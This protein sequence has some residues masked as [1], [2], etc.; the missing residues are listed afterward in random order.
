MKNTFAS[1]L[2]T[3]QTDAVAL[4]K[5]DLATQGFSICKA[6]V[7][8]GKMHMAGAVAE[9]GY[10]VVSIYCAL[11]AEHRQ[12]WIDYWTAGDR[13]A[14]ARLKP[15]IKL[16]NV[17][18]ADDFTDK[19]RVLAVISD[20]FNNAFSFGLFKALRVKGFHVLVV[21]SNGQ[22]YTKEWEELGGHS[23]NTWDLHPGVTEKGLNHERDK[24]FENYKMR[25]CGF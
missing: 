13:T 20:P 12:N 8:S 4:M 6:G 3:A 7:G 2:F 1:I 24:H 23:Y 21:G 5:S 15:V 25:Y 16:N 17:P 19:R 22:H 10:E 14:A 18:C 11:A 9:E